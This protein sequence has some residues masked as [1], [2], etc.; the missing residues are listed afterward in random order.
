[1]AKCLIKKHRN[2]FTFT[3]ICF[4]LILNGN[5]QDKYLPEQYRRHLTTLETGSP[6]IYIKYKRN[7]S[8]DNTN[9]RHEYQVHSDSGN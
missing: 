7:H 3:I 8:V 6:Q 4:N 5:E 1:M 2:K 9:K